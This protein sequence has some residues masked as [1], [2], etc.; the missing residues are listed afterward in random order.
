[1]AGATITIDDE[2]LFGPYCVVVAS[3]HTRLER[4]FRYGVTLTQPIHVASGCWIAAHV[5]ITAGSEVGP[6]TL[7]AASAVV[8]GRLPGD[9]LVG[10]QPAK[11]IREYHATSQ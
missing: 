9:S 2:V 5:T 8:T 4:S 7:V 6:G 11:V 3:N 1:M 10:G